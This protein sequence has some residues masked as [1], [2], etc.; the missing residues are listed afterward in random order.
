MF[1]RICYSFVAHFLEGVSQRVSLV[2]II[3]FEMSEN[4]EKN[5]KG[6]FMVSPC[7]KFSSC[8]EF[9]LAE[10][11]TLYLLNPKIRTRTK[12]SLVKNQ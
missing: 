4:S 1:V 11:F 9:F 5:L 8:S 3:T 12:N 10:M 6:F 7:H 2:K